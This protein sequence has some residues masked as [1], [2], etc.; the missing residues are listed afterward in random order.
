MKT[1]FYLL[2]MVFLLLI[3]CQP[4]QVEEEVVEEADTPDYA[5]FDE[6][7]AVLRAFI[8]AH[9]DEDLATQS[10]FLSDTLSWSPPDYNGNQWLGK[11]DYLAVLEGYHQGFEN[12]KFAEGIVQPNGNVAN[13]MW[14]GSTFPE[15]TATSD[16]VAIRIYG[17]WTATHTESGKDVGVKWMAVAF[18]TEDNKIGS[19]TEF[20]DVNGLAAQIAAE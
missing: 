13:G 2:A 7:V 19:L 17:T 18:M 6:R 8:Q 11:E 16:P 9:C 12:V 14:S 5:L 10:S 3:A 15:A 1:P 4:T 20:F